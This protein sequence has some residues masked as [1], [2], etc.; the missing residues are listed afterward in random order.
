MK[1]KKWIAFII[2]MLLVAFCIILYCSFEGNPI[3]CMIV[4]HH[5]KEYIK[6]NYSNYKFDISSSSYN[7]KDGH[8]V[9]SIQDQNSI[10]THFTLEYDWQGELIN[11]HYDDVISGFNTFYRLEEEYRKLVEE[12]MEATDFPLPKNDIQFG[13]LQDKEDNEEM[14][15]AAFGIEKSK[16]IL[17]KEYDLKEIGKDAGVIVCY[18]EDQDVS[19]K[20]TRQMLLKL[21][22]YLHQNDIY[23]Y[24][25]DFH[26]G[27]SNDEESIDLLKFLSSDIYSKDLD[28]RI[29]KG[30]RK[31]E[32]YYQEQD[33]IK[34]EEINK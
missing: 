20:N 5:A 33:K 30:I 21:K 10:D 18:V 34:E 23:F 29:E 13:T 22:A 14:I 28:K 27:R 4:D 6:E 7:F 3:S 2:A 1:L 17:D 31:T 26:L 25:V 12:V 24:A 8:Y 11:D 32:K 16:L 9:V 15:C 19:I